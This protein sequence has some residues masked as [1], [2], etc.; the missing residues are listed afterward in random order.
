MKI[1]EGGSN[2][3]EF[4]ELHN[5]CSFLATKMGIFQL[6]RKGPIADAINHILLQATFELYVNPIQINLDQYEAILRPEHNHMAE[7]DNIKNYTRD[8]SKMLSSIRIDMIERELDSVGILITCDGKT[9]L[10]FLDNSESFVFNSHADHELSSKA[11]IIIFD[12]NEEIVSYL[13]RYFSSEYL[14]SIPEDEKLD[15]NQAGA[16]MYV[17]TSFITIKN[18][19]KIEMKQEIKVPL[20]VS[21]EVKSEKIALEMILSDINMNIKKAQEDLKHYTSEEFKDIRE[22]ILKHIGEMEVEQ[23]KYLETLNDKFID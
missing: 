18:Q 8:F 23:I 2:Q 5:A 21:V 13:K 20:E 11:H 15:F 19:K 6:I 22:N 4:K 10:L 17:E 3:G 9:I 7:L 1:I 14:D 16:F 12:S